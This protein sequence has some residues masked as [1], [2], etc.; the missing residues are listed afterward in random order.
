[1]PVRLGNY[2]FYS[3]IH[4]CNSSNGAA[5]VCLSRTAAAES[6]FQARVLH[7]DSVLLYCAIFLIQL[8]RSRAA[9]IHPF[10]VFSEL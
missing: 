4:L 3:F 1:M 10:N 7:I 8:P 2:L 5:G 6:G 9:S